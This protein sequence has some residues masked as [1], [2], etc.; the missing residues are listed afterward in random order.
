MA[1]GLSQRG[2]VVFHEG[3]VGRYGPIE[4]Q[5]PEGQEIDWHVVTS[6]MLEA[7]HAHHWM[8]SLRPD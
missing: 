6:E 7:S 3:P 4:V 2:Y 8:F 5:S 1:T